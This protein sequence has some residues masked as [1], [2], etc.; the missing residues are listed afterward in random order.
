MCSPQSQKKINRSKANTGKQTIIYK[1]K[2][3]KEK[4]QWEI[5][6]KIQYLTSFVRSHYKT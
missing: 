1:K 6:Q 5:D 3:Q 4:V 2:S